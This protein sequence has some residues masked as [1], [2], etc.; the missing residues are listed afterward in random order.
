MADTFE[1]TY[2]HPRA[3]LFMN[4]EVGR[5]VTHAE[6]LEHHDAVVYGVGA[7]E[8]RALGIPGE[9]LPGVHGATETVAWYN[10]DPGVAPDA[11]RPVDGRVFV[12]GNG[13]V[14]LDVARILLG[15]VDRLA[16]TEI[17][18][19]ALD[20]LRRSD[21]REV[22]LLGRR[23]PEHAAFTRP[24]LLTLPD[25]IELLVED[26]ERTAEALDQAERGSQAALLAPFPRVRSDWTT[27]PAPGRRLVLAFGR[28]V[29]R[30]EGDGSLQRITITGLEEDV[31]ASTR[32]LVCST[33]RRGRAVPGVPFDESVGLIPNDRGHVLD[34]AGQPVTGT[35]VV[36]WAKRGARGGIGANRAC[37]QETV[38]RLLRDASAGRLTSPR[39]SSGAFEALLRKRQPRL[40][41]GKGVAA[42]EKHEK[43]AGRKAGRPRVKLTSEA[44]LLATARR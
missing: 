31:V 3:H 36:G 23:G 40:V 13:N 24:E 10:G 38:E 8:D 18:D 30:A 42:I 5:H 16:T 37:A 22:V 15:D 28:Q 39:R 26:D 7:P 19:H 21:V 9:E 41:R 33:G 1:W 14:A 17:A 25:G 44:E 11:V 4:V 34:L 27:E 43:A 20:V 12:V 6:L 29:V 32:L 2:R 35:F